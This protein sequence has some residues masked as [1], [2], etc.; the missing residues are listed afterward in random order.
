MS[1]IL[2]SQIVTRRG[3]SLAFKNIHGAICLLFALSLLNAPLFADFFFFTHFCD[4]S[5]ISL[6]Q[7]A[8]IL[9]F[10]HHQWIIHSKWNI[11]VFPCSID[12]KTKTSRNEFHNR[13]LCSYNSSGPRSDYQ[14]FQSNFLSLAL[15]EVFEV[16]LCLN[17]SRPV[18]W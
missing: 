18:F 6:R 10:V 1:C 9:I 14:I 15:C 11:C 2:H 8:G 4:F 5:F 17:P 13:F 7:N 3:C 16:F 12:T